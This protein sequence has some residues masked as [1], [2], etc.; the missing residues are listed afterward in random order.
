[1]KAGFL[2]RLRPKQGNPLRVFGDQVEARTDLWFGAW[3][4]PK[5]TRLSRSDPAVLA[6]P[7]GHLFQYPPVVLTDVLELEKE[8]N[9][10]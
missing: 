7:T 5:G 6:D 2:P 9:D 4:I 8:V 1:V 10:G 3:W